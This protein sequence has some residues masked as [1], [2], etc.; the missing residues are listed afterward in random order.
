MPV[1]AALDSFDDYVGRFTAFATKTASASWTKSDY[2]FL[3]N[4]T[5]AATYT[6]PAVSGAAAPRTGQRFIVKDRSSAGA[7]VYN[8]TI[9]VPSGAVLDGTTNGTA[10]V[11]DR[12][13]WVEVVFDGS[14][15]RTVRKSALT[16]TIA[17]VLDGGGAA[18]AVGTKVYLEVP[19]ACT[20]T[21]WTIIADQSG[22]IV[23]DVWKDVYAN[24]PP[25]VADTIAGSEKPTISAATK[26]QDLSLTTW[27][28]P[29]AAGDIIAF[30][31]DSCTTITRAT[32]SLRVARL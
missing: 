1:N 31:V 27:T 5:A 26:G 16:A 18:I 21:G 32:V 2:I 22:S 12:G 8:I 17:C 15:Y 30:N 24:Y 20:I 10:T 19:F 6:L 13:G 3:S 11:S 29:V 25:T 4:H 14:G 23:V 7:D 9:A 28:L